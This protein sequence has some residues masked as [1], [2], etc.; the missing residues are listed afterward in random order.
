MGSD[1]KNEKCGEI[2]ER[3]RNGENELFSELIQIFK[4]K[5]FPVAYGFFRDRDEALD[6]AQEVF[7]RLWKM[8]KRI[9]GK[10][11]ETLGYEGDKKCM[12]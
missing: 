8:A 5:I 9:E 11:I 10:D 7:I 2:L 6:I 3:I 4:G 1:G 12:Y